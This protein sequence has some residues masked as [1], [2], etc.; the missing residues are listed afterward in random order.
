M[1]SLGMSLGQ[2]VMVSAAIG[3]TFLL[4]PAFLGAPFNAL[5]RATRGI[6]I[7]R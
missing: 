1:D 4:S 5:E 7:G 2:V 6:M 3:L